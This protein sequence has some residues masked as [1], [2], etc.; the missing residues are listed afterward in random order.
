[1]RLLSND[2]VVLGW[3]PTQPSRT[4]MPTIV[5]LRTDTVV[6]QFRARARASAL[7][8]RFALTVQEAEGGARDRS[9]ARGWPARRHSSA[10]SSATRSSVAP[11]RPPWSCRASIRGAGYRTVAARRRRG[12]D[13]PRR[14]ALRRARRAAGLGLLRAARTPAPRRGRCARWR[15]R[16]TPACV[17]VPARPQLRDR[18][19]HSPPAPLLDS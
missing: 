13:A 6:R 14:R 19:G 11:P 10:G 7:R 2:R 1:V 9:D 3:T 12:G 4:A 18:S 17:R 8:Y 16:R 5:S 15:R